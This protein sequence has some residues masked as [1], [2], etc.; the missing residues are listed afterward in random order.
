M[1]NFEAIKQWSFTFISARKR[2]TV[3]TQKPIQIVEGRTSVIPGGKMGH[4]RN[5]QNQ[6]NKKE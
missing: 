5:Q 2:V 3:H 4:L 6:E 1:F